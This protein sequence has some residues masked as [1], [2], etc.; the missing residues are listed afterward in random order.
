MQTVGKLDDHH[1][2]VAVHRHE[3]LAERLCLLIVQVFDLDLRD[4]RDA[5]HELGDLRREL[6]CD[7]FFGC[8]GVFNGIV[9]ERGAEHFD[10]H[11]QIG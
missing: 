2:N 1:A 6:F 5:I 10:V 8:S 11:A 9:Q 4:L 7:L 3:H